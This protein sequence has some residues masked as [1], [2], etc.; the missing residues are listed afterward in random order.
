MK[1]LSIILLLGII[2]NLTA[3]DLNNYQPL[4]CSG[5]LPKDFTDRTS[6]KVINDIKINTVNTESHLA[7]KAKNNFLL[8]SNYLLDELLMSG[9]VLFGDSVSKYVN[10]VADNLLINEPELRKE[11][12]FYCLKSNVTNAFCTN[13]GMIFVTLGLIAQLENEAQLA[14]VLAHEITHYTK[15]H[16]INTFIESSK[17]SNGKDKYNNY[18]E[19]IL[20][21][22]NYS[23]SLE[24]EADSIGF[25]RLK[26]AGYSIQEALSLFDV[27]QFSYLPFDEET[28]T[29][30]YFETDNVK[31]PNKYKLDSIVPIKFL[32]D[33]DDSKSTHPNVKK[34]KEQISHLI[35]NE[36]SGKTYI[37]SKVLFNKI[38][39]ISRFEGIR[40][41]NKNAE[42]VKA[43]YNSK[44]LL[45]KYPNSNFL[46]ESILKAL[47]GISKYKCANKYRFISKDFSVYEGEISAAYYFFEKLNEV[48]I[49][50]I[51]L[52]KLNEYYL[53]NKNNTAIKN[54][55]KNLI[56]DLVN[57]QI[58]FKNYHQLTTSESTIKD[59]VKKEVEKNTDS[60]YAKLRA[61]KKQQENA[62]SDQS[63]DS[64]NFYE[65]YLY[66]SSNIEELN[67][68]FDEA[69][70]IKKN[71]AN[72]I[73]PYQGM[74][75]RQ[76][77][78]EIKKNK[79][80]RYKNVNIK[81]N[82][83]VFV[84]PEYIVFN[85]RKG[86]KLENAE[87]KKYN[88]YKQIDLVSGKIGIE[89]EILSPKIFNID[90][91]DK[92]NDLAKINDWIN[93]KNI[94][95]KYKEDWDFIPLEQ[96]YI[97]YLTLKY[98]TSTF[99]YSGVLLY[100]QPKE[101]AMETLIITLF[102][103]P[104][105]PYG[106]YNAITPKYLTYYYNL[107]Y[108]INTNKSFETLDELKT[109]ANQ[110]NIN[111]LMYDMLNQVKK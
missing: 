90:D 19:N 109:K 104:L 29:Y 25:F 87:R 62:L 103:F 38:R 2:I 36:M 53:Q 94:H 34:R 54:R 85:E 35:N 43:I 39:A 17:I 111:S 100:K 26:N 31:I 42:Y 80:D 67:N 12:R 49:T 105:L 52:E 101:N 106:I 71:N 15:K 110:A 77:K 58:C 59:T 79:K 28:F 21:L 1:L 33:Y 81:T 23:K 83:V 56:R 61:I 4:I 14:Q 97:N 65:E 41:S 98:K 3:Q 86:Q 50:S 47:Y 30:S 68:W 46:H 8:K 32:D 70:I 40:L 37:Q 55:I 107:W 76:K 24:F 57:E 96:E 74:T 48:Q 16:V 45:K 66:S 99:L 92:Y 60:K 44:I 93:E 73:N 20:K 51:T 75:Y 84:D 63:L 72:L 69:I 5:P 91:Y 7:K 102:Y 13:Q 11:L 27:L 10:T 89:Y 18:D 78:K 82:K 108:D 88:F 9:R 6:E 64:D 22:S 95:K